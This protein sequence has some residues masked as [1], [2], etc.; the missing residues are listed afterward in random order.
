[1]SRKICWLSLL[2]AI[3]LFLS[4]C[5]EVLFTNRSRVLLYSESD[6]SALALTSYQEVLKTEKLSTNSQEINRL[7]NIGN[8]IVSAVVDLTKDSSYYDLIKKYQWEFK[9]IDKPDVLNAF[10]LPGGKVVVYTGMLKVA[11][12]DDQLATVISHEIAHALAQHGNERM[13]QQTMVQ[14]GGALLNEAVKNNTEKDI[15]TFNTVYS[16]GANLGVMLPYSR[17]H[18]TEADHIGLLIMAKAGY[19]PNQA[20]VLWENMLQANP[21]G[22]NSDFFSTHPATRTRINDLK[23]F[24]P[25]AQAYSNK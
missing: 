5:N 21:D 15:Q 3:I 19:D 10:C 16:L 17:S 11:K 2:V 13:S 12:N 8:R 4:G 25:E 14:A 1:M 9:L 22:G 18:E 20:I 23:K 7:Q 6:L 24:M